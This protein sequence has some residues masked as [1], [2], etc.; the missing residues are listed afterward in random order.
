MEL[1]P[2]D[3]FVWDYS[4]MGMLGTDVNRVFRDLFC[5]G[6]ERNNIPFILL[7]IVA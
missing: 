5:F 7:A 2:L 4:G 1:L 3:A 6:N